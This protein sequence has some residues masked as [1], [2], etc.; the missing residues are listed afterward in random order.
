MGFSDPDPDSLP[1]RIAALVHAHFDGLPTRSKPAIHDGM[2]EWIPMTGI[3][4]VKGENTPE[5]KLTCVAVTTGAKCLPASQIPTC[6]GM[7]LHDCHAEILAMR[8]FNFWLLSECYALLG[9]ENHSS[10]DPDGSASPY[11]WRRHPLNPSGAALPP[12]ELHPDVSIYMYCTCAPCGDASMEL[13]I[14]AQND[15]TPWALP[16]RTTSV[17]S[18]SG[19]CDLNSSDPSLL[20]GRAHFSNLGIV[21]RKPARADAESTKSKSCSD[22]LALRQV[23]SVLSYEASLLVAVTGNAYIKGL[24]LPEEE[25]TRVG[26]ARCFGADGRMKVLKGRAWPVT[27]P[28]GSGDGNDNGNGGPRIESGNW[29]QCRYEFRPF[30]ILSIPDTQLKSLWPFRKPKA[31]DPVP[32]GES[33]D[34]EA[35]QIPRPKKS[36]PGNISAVWVRAPTSGH[37]DPSHPSNTISTDNG[38]KNLPFLRGSKTGLFEN[39]IN[40]VRQGH[41][42]SSPGLRGASALS[43]AKLWAY[44]SKIIAAAQLFE[45]DHVVLS[46]NEDGFIRIR[47]TGTMSADDVLT[48][49][50]FKKEPPVLKECM[51]AR[52][53]AMKAAKEVLEGWVSNSGDEDW[54]WGI[55][56]LGL[57]R[58]GS[59]E[60]LHR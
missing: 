35:T 22:K 32:D 50:E 4:L 5:E 13:V 16:N 26:C 18:S 59:V 39:I 52:A 14:A 55:V 36:K 21:R 7:V 43:R 28:V 3:V 40:G 53:N 24:V 19:G 10:K 48:Y 11:I 60:F 20:D 41:R 46:R 58:N 54:G 37:E 27:S 9:H 6:N 30:E 12:F 23:T 1:S 31:S 38:R 47:S 17:E 29:Q 2:A 56:T 33:K 34:G 8:A 57:R 44:C 49:R 51:E 42:A 25:I 15:P 45:G